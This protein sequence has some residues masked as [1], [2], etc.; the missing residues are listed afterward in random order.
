MA[1]GKFTVTAALPYANGPLHL[2]HIAG[3]Y[4]PADMTNPSIEIMNALGQKV[5]GW[6]IQNAAKTGEVSI[7]MSNVPDGVYFLKVTSNGK[8]EVKRFVKAD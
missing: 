7:N 6:M 4:L 5:Q 3:V 1:G 8:V 2:G